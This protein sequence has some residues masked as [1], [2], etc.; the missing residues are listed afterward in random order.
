MKDSRNSSF[1]FPPAALRA[2][3]G[4]GRA[5]ECRLPNCGK[6]LCAVPQIG[7][8]THITY[9]FAYL[10]LRITIPEFL[11]FIGGLNFA[12]GY[13]RTVARACHQK[14][15]IRPEVRVDPSTPA[16][17]SYQIRIPAGLYYHQLC[18]SLWKCSLT[19]FLYF[20]CPLTA[21]WRLGLPQ[22]GSRPPWW[23]LPLSLRMSR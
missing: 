10:R 14:A 4:H 15:K 9:L 7:V 8:C 1:R 11:K 12:P 19:V 23:L 16:Y 20:R 21:C 5:S 2:S 6:K 13:K 17:A 18:S 22:G 3:E